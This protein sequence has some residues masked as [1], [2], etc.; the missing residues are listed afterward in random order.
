MQTGQARVGILDRR[1]LLVPNLATCRELSDHFEI[2]RSRS[3][4]VSLIGAHSK[5][6]R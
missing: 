4:Q 3:E 1:E 5:V 6:Q 2:N